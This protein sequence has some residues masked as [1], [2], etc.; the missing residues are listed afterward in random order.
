VNRLLSPIRAGLPALL[1]TL[2][3]S[4]CAQVQSGSGW[5]LMLPPLSADGYADKSAPLSKWQT[6][7]TY[8]GQ[9]DCNSSI[10]S[11]QMAVHSQV[12]QISRAGVPSEALPVQMMSAQCVASDDPALKPQ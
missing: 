2:L 6:F 3:A 9:I 7:G 11:N 5:L 12:G 8:S 4:G 1:V 10:A